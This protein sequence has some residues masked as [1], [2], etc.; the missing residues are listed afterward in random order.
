MFLFGGIKMLSKLKQIKSIERKE[1]KIKDM[2]DAKLGDVVYEI[3][4]TD[5]AG[6]NRK[7]KARNCILKFQVIKGKSNDPRYSWYPFWGL[8][9]PDKE[10]APT[11]NLIYALLKEILIHETRVDMTRNRKS[12]SIIWKK[13]LIEIGNSIQRS[14][15]ECT[16]PDIYRY[17][18]E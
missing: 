6:L 1:K 18:E 7:C 3:Y 4:L 2:K 8:E 15:E 10:C 11:R 16:F 14:L 13:R 9:L 5:V 17:D 12:D